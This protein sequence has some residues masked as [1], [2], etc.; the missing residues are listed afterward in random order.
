[1]NASINAVSTCLLGEGIKHQ[2]SH[3]HSTRLCSV[4]LAEKSAVEV[5]GYFA[6]KVTC[7][8]QLDST[9]GRSNWRCHLH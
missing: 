7:A 6:M 5:M 8:A 9:I 3:S 1:M 4:K 2:V